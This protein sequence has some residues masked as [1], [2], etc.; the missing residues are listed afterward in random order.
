MA[1]HAMALTAE[2]AALIRELADGDRE[3]AATE[4]VRTYQRFV[5]SVALRH[6]EGN[7]DDAAD[8]AQETFIRALRALPRF[9][10]ESSIQ[11]WLY[12]ITVNTCRSF[13]R[14]WKRFVS[15]SEVVET[16]DDL[17]SHLPTPD[18]QLEDDEFIERFHAM[19][20]KLPPK[21]RETFYLRY[22]EGLSYEEISDILGTSVSGLKANYYHA[23]RRIAEMLGRPI[24][25]GAKR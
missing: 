14:R 15:L 19:L 16:D 12:R 2:E 18:R 20:A 23:V 25:K 4:F 11:T 5:Y 1:S 17:A 9:K 10:G 7:H 3:R 21:Q 8:V 22:V 13:R 24:P 6:V